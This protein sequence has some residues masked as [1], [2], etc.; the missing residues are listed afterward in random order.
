MA[1]SQKCVQ[2]TEAG[3]DA[4]NAIVNKALGYPRRGTRAGGGIHVDAPPTWDGQGA[5]PSGWTK[6]A[7]ANYVASPADAALPLPDTLVTEL[8]KGPAQALLSGAEQTTLAVAIAGRVTVDLDAGG[9]V[10]KASA[11]AQATIEAEVETKL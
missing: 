3:N 1:N 11:V 6:Q 9:R 8:Q 5:C 10:P 2:A 4:L 7:V